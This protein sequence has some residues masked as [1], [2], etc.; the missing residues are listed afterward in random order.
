MPVT[1]SDYFAVTEYS[2]DYEFDGRTV[3]LTFWHRPLSA[4]ADSFAD[5]GF[6]IRT[7]SEP[8]PGPDTPADLLPPDLPPGGRFICFL[9]LV[10]EAA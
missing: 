5:A 6:R 3:W 2:E 4:M 9:F 10:L 8:A 1:D 7:I